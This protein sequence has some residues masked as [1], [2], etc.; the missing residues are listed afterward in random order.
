MIPELAAWTRTAAP[1][2]GEGGW[3]D[4]DLIEAG[5]AL[6]ARL[7]RCE[8]ALREMRATAEECL[9]VLDVGDGTRNPEHQVAEAWHKLSDALPA[10]PDALARPEGA[11]GV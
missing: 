10:I 8:A 5:D 1:I 2:R 4:K 6:A 11:S 3:W 9:L 7:E